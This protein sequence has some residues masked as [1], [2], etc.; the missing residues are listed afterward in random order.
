MM[1]M[2]VLLARLWVAEVVKL[3]SRPLARMGWVVLAVLAF[4]V[5]LALN[6]V[7][8]ADFQVNGQATSLASSPAEGVAAALA[9]RNF[10]VAQILLLVLAATTLAGEYQARTLREDLLRP[11]PRWTVLMAKWA[12]LATWSAGALL[13]QWVVAVVGAL[14]FLSAEGSTAWSSVF[15]GYAVTVATDASFLAVALLVALLTRSVTS[16]IAGVFLFLV[17]EGFVYWLLWI[18][19][20]LRDSVTGT[21]RTILDA[22][23]F[24]PH[25]AWGVGTEIAN[26]GT[27]HWGSWA[28][29]GGLTVIALVAA[30]RVFART[31]VP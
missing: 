6:F 11:V 15:W 16:T 1:S 18:G 4:V 28:V 3:S 27:P 23:P 26:G 29:L 24:L 5:V 13:V 14:V 9:V 25:S 31:D 30:E 10:Y 17:F 21:L 20:S 7:G 22:L 8:G 12:A 19:Q 2:P